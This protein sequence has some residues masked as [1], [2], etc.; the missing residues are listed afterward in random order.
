MVVAL[1]A[2]DGQAKEGFAERVHAIDEGF[3]AKLFGLD[4][5]FLVEHRVAQ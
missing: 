1:A 3:D 5:S 4:P 2:V